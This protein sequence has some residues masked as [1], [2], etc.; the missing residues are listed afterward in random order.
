MGFLCARVRAF[1]AESGARAGASAAQLA[2][3]KHGICCKASHCL[4]VGVNYQ[5][6]PAVEQAVPLGGFS[7]S[8]VRCANITGC[9]RCRCC[10]PG[11]WA[12]R[13]AALQL[14]SERSHLRIPTCWAPCE[15]CCV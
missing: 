14:W 2:A 3:S 15:Q 8:L 5:L 9:C 1:S 11:C 10:T 12:C 13:P 6:L 4:S 7:T